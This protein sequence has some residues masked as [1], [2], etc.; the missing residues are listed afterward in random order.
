MPLHRLARLLD[1]I[2]DK[3]V[4]RSY[5]VAFVLIYGTDPCLAAPVAINPCPA[6]SGDGPAA[7]PGPKLLGRAP[8]YHLPSRQKPRNRQ[9]LTMLL[10]GPCLF[11]LLGAVGRPPLS[12]MWGRWFYIWVGGGYGLAAALPRPGAP[13]PY[14][15]RAGQ[16]IASRLISEYLRLLAGYGYKASGLLIN[17]QSWCRSSCEYYYFIPSAGRV[18]GMSAVNMD[19][20]ERFEFLAFFLTPTGNRLREAETNSSRQSCLRFSTQFYLD[21]SKTPEGT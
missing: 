21:I 15:L 16:N 19:L 17:Q 2:A 14:P 10:V 3:G 8:M 5:L 7:L 11:V 9:A 12:T 18:T 6:I 4:D 20:T 1:P 13:G